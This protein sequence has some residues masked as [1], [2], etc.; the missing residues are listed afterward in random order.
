MIKYIFLLSCFFITASLSAQVNITATLPS[1]ALYLRSQLWNLTISNNNNVPIDVSMQMEMKDIQTH[2]TVL[3]ATSG[4]FSL[5]PGVKITQSEMLEPLQYFSSAGGADRSGNGF[6]S[7]GQYQVCYQLYRVLHTEKT[8]LADD[9]EQLEVEPMSQPVLTSPE[10]DSVISLNNPTFTWTAP[11]PIMMFVDLNYDLIIAEVNNGQSPGEAIRK[12]IPF[13]QAS[14]IQQ[15]FFNL[16]IQGPQLEKDKVYAWQIVAKDQQ[17]FAARSEVW[18][19]KTGTKADKIETGNF[20][21]LLMEGN[22]AGVGTSEKDVLHIK[23]VSN[24]AVHIVPIIFRDE[25]GHTVYKTKREIKQGDNL[26]DI[27]LNSRF[28]AGKKYTVS[29]AENERSSSLIFTIKKEQE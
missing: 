22:V 14:N 16:S 10:N 21:Y 12:N 24:M 2:Q 3:S 7:V 11:T 18:T 5:L 20:T 27:P 4:I 26:L 6:L 29:I 23:Y 15:P 19:F 8:L 13:A 17:R 1:G 28:T 9:C 25:T